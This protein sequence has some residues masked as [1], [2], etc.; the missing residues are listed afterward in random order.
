L[1]VRKTPDIPQDFFFEESKEEGAQ[2]AAP[3]TAKRQAVK[4]ANSQN[5]KQ[6]KRLAVKQSSSQKVQVTIYLSEAAAKELERLRFEL[7]D[8]HNVKA[9]RSAIV[10]AA[11]LGVGERLGEVVEALGE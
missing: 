11:L 8:K 9:S 10:E 1:A 2:P 5:V 4:P 3:V 6:S 7:L